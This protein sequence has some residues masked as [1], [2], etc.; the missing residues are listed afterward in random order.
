VR[1]GLRADEARYR[2]NSFYSADPRLLV[3]HAVRV[4]RPPASVTISSASAEPQDGRLLVRGLAPRAWLERARVLAQA[5]PGVDNVEWRVTESEPRSK[6]AELTSRLQSLLVLFP[7][8]SA[9]IAPRSAA[10]DDVARTIRE[11]LSLA[12]RLTVQLAIDV[13]GHADPHGTVER[14]QAL[15]RLRVEKVISEL[16]ARGVPATVLRPQVGPVDPGADASRTRCGGS[17]QLR[18]DQCARR[19]DFHVDLQPAPGVPE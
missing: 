2:L 13:V 9:Q 3:R 8:D 18:G 19:V 15:R 10:L 14:N 12:Q 5:L 1:G 17:G 16:G 11:A 6:L 7:N 4:L